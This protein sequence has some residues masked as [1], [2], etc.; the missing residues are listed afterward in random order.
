MTRICMIAYTHY[1]RDPRVR[2]EA[3]A[4]AG[5]GDTVDFICE[6]EPDK[7]KRQTCNGVNLHAISV[8][9]Y[10]G[11]STLTYIYR[12]ACFF[13]KSFF[14]VSYLFFKNRYDVVQVHTMPDFL[15]FA[16][17]VPKVFGAKVVLDVHDLMPEL[18]ICKFKVRPEHP[19][20]RLITWVERMSI[21]FAHRAIAV[22]EPH[23]KA[24]LSH[25]NPAAK[26]EILLNVPDPA[27][28]QTRKTGRADERFRLVYHGT[29]APR[30]GLEVALRAVHAVK[31]RIPQLELLII[32]AGEDL[33]RLK[34]LAGE[35]DIKE[36]VRFVPPMPVEDLPRHLHQAD[37]GIVP[38]LYD[39]FTRYMLPLKLL[40]YV[41]LGIPVISSRTETIEAYFGEGMIH[42]CQP[43]DVD[44]LAGAI[45]LLHQY[46]EKRRRLVESSATFAVT[47]NWA[48]QKVVY[49]R[50][51]DSLLKS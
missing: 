43:G 13:A 31:A 4:L 2:R 41:G 47:H 39:E 35:L 9:R 6:R 48:D 46:P 10:Q 15:V 32:G 42:F 19:N 25:G 24:L 33:E 30:H 3:E 37:V 21:A 14:L 40:E 28:F 5:R 49:F 1:S 50:L 11:G 16:A 36:N 51:I 12:Y 20:I 22:H 29:I 34:K 45:L 23:L 7:P 27:I 26:F 17:L 44:D 38:I 18:Y 8:G